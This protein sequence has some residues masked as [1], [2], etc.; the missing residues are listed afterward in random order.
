MASPR[1]NRRTRP[2]APRSHDD[3]PAPRVIGM[4]WFA[5]DDYATFRRLL[6]GRRWHATFQ[7]WER[8]AEK[9]RRDVQADLHVRV[10]RVPVRSH[11]FAAWCRH[12]RRAIDY[13]SL[14]EYTTTLADGDPPT[15][16]APALP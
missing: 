14:H 8:G 10:V 6:P 15:D 2:G 11:D 12:H 5:E 9:L 3:A 13:D 7:A 16:D 4:P 1:P